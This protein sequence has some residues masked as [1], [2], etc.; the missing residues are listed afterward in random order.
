MKFD[1][2]EKFFESNRTRF[3]CLLLALATVSVYWP[4]G[5]F[6][7]T[8]YDDRYIILR[9]PVVATGLTLRAVYW[10]LTTSYYEFWHPITWWSHM[11]DCELFGLRPGAHHLMSLGI[12][13][14]NTLLL[15]AALRRMT[16]A[17]WR[18][19]MVAALF[20]LH[21]LHVEPVAWL[22]ERKELLCTF[23][24]LLSLWTYAG[25]V[26]ESAMGGM[27]A[28]RLYRLTLLFFAFGLMAKP[29]AVTL[30][31]VLLLLDYWPL[32]RFTIFNFKVADPTVG[33]L[34][35]LTLRQLILEKLPFFGL[36]LVSCAIT[37]TGVSRAHNILSADTVPWGLRLA[38]IPVSYAR[39]LGKLIWPVDLAIHYPM[40]GRWDVWQVTGAVVLVLSVSGLVLIWSRSRPYLLMGWLLFLGTLAPTIGLVPVGF[41]SIADRYTYFPSIGLFVA[42]VWAVADLSK[43]WRLPAV[44]LGV[45][46]VLT[47]TACGV[48]TWF[49]VQ[50]WRN[51][52]TL[53]THCLAVTK[54]N[55]IAHFQ[56][57]WALQESGRVNEAMEQYRAALRINPNHYSANVYL[58]VA[59]F[60]A[61]RLQEATNYYANAL[62][63]AP[64]YVLAHVH[65][66]NALSKLGD[67]AGATN[68][69]F[70]ILRAK[71][72]DANIRGVCALALLGLAD[73]SGAF[74]QA[75][76]A[77]NLNPR[78]FWAYIFKGRAS[79]ALG[80]SDE[81][82]Q[83]YF[84]AL[85]LNANTHEVHFRLGQE[86]MKRGQLDA[87]IASFTEALRC[88]P[89]SAETHFELG[90]A[91]A[92]QQGHGKEA[93][94]HYREALQLDPDLL[95]ALNNL[96]WLLAVSPGADVRNGA[97]AVLLAERACER[98]GYRETDFIGTLAAAY[99]EAGQFDKA[100]ETAQKA[101]AL[102]SSL[103]QTV[104]VARNLEL[105]QRYKN[106]EPYHERK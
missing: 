63:I 15:F 104:L 89:A 45:A 16:G 94:S 84:M 102:A 12:H 43:H 24:C 14:A 39:Y 57:G 38:N 105:L 31:C 50:H 82:L 86:W 1:S 62:H 56:W 65:M 80:R 19:T 72:N 88:D 44:G 18:S 75:E 6:D 2:A 64:Y 85:S 68:H 95:V 91:L 106:R 46:A 87:A 41:Q 10:G 29:M 47:L 81:A 9:N 35:R 32:R 8:N 76:Q 58:G 33:S 52:F 20:A 71:P 73:F 98:T 61:G 54:E 25:Y 28:K 7:F 93:I 70:T 59:L 67:F 74:E 83:S 53:W 22:A 97:E 66:G 30:P 13:V 3:I 100:V 92:R 101:C 37:L 99:A 23:F 51:S 90:A 103:G 42:A 27:R 96:A 48:L 17:M 11:L 60:E 79:S 40:P 77:V 49:Q 69:Y 4:V 26:R 55:A 78:D 5:F 34:Q 21:P 36:T